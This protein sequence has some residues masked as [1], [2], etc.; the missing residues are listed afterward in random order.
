MMPVTPA[1][2]HPASF[3]QKGKRGME[4]I[5]DKYR[6]GCHGEFPSATRPLI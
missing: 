2:L 5:P 3:I 1:S 4:S 6:A